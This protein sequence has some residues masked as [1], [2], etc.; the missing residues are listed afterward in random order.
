VLDE[1]LD[2]TT[3]QNIECDNVIKDMLVIVG[4]EQQKEISPNQSKKIPTLPTIPTSFLNVIDF[5]KDW[6]CKWRPMYEKS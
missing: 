2:I 1:T 3:L 4:I 6:Q 5:Y